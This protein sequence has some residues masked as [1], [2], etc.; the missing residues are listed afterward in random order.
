MSKTVWLKRSEEWIKNNPGKGTMYKAVPETAPREALMS[1]NGTNRKRYEKKPEGDSDRGIYVI[2][3]EIAKAA[4][5]GQSYNMGVRMRNHKAAILGR[6]S[7]Q[8]KT[9]DKI[10]KDVTTHGIDSIIFT[11]HCFVSEN[12]SEN[13]TEKEN[14]VMY[15]YLNKGYRLYNCSIPGNILCPEKHLIL[16]NSL[17]EKLKYSPELADKITVLIN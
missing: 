15:Y 10:K 2:I 16:I 8:N 12:S 1:I 6:I 9:Y 11:K 14:E 5:I 13:L 7:S 4:Y 3:C 17:I